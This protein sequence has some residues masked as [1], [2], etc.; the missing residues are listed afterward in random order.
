MIMV[1]GGAYQG[2]ASYVKKEYPSVTFVSGEEIGVEDL[3]KAEGVLDLHLLIRKELKEGRDVSALAERLIRENPDII[4]VSDEIGYGVVPMEPFDRA[5]RE[6]VGRICTTLADFS[7]KVIRV[8]CGIG[9]VIK[10]TDS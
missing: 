7:T 2:K 5:Y 4:V 3:M 10:E 9:M 1:I 8:V 6:A